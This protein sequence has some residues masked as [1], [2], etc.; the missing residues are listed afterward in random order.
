[1]FNHITV[2]CLSVIYTYIDDILLKNEKFKVWLIILALIVSL[3]GMFSI[4][5]SGIKI[6]IMMLFVKF[7]YV[8]K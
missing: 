2:L 4:E 8:L 1:M 6:M 5:N 3:L 7:Y